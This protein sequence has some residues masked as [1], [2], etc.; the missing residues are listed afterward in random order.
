MTGAAPVLDIRRTARTLSAV[1]NRS[2]LA[3]QIVRDAY[4]AARRVPVVGITGPPGAGKS[5]LVDRLAVDWAERGEK[6]AVLAI[7][8][9]S[10]FTGGALLGDRVRMEG[11][12]CHPNVF[13]RSLASRGEVGGL[14]S[15]AHD[16]VTVLAALG[17]DR[18]VLETVGAGQADVAVAMLADVVV[19]VSVPGLGDEVQAA[20]AGILEIGDV[21]VV[22]KSDLQGAATVFAHLAANLDLVYTG[23]PGRNT[24]PGPATVRADRSP[25]RRHGCS[26]EGSE[27]WRPPLLTICAQF[28]SVAPVRAAADEFLAW[29]RDTGHYAERFRDRLRSQILSAARD[30]LMR[31]CL[32]AVGERRVDLDGLTAAVANGAVSPH[33][34]AERL[35]AELVGRHDDVSRDHAPYGESR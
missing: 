20:K 29:S 8:P 13:V 26:A 16:M 11:A 14:T 9:S 32:I 3:D 27:Y 5:T 21:F 24:A 30:R 10:P 34:A 28:G 12:A 19:V 15:T 4:C 18:I 22:N 35:T 2:A 1:E 25:Q 7:D 6:V 17:F 33:E 23:A 31:M